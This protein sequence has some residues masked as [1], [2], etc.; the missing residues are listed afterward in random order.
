MTTIDERFRE[1]VRLFDE[2][3]YFAAHEAWEEHWLIEKDETR[4]LLLQALIQVAAA[5]HK[6]V[7]ANAPAPAASLFAKALAKLDRC[8]PAL[9]GLD[10][11]AFRER[12]RV[13]AVDLAAGRY[14]ASTAAAVTLTPVATLKGPERGPARR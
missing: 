14:D 3:Q 1:G 5:L 13:C 2:R 4:R 6:L 11:A 10:V 8:P 9:D 7:V 12:V